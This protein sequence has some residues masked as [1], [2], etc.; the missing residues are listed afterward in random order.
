V[1]IVE[2]FISFIV[3]RFTSHHIFL[4]ASFAALFGFFYLKSIDLLYYSY[5]EKPGWNSK[6]FLSLFIIVLPITAINGF[7]MW[8]AAWIFFF[9]AYHVILYRD[10]RYLLI[11]LLACL[12]HWSFIL[13]N[14]VLLIYFFAGNRNLIY[15]PVAIASFFVPDSLI[16]V[17]NSIALKLGGAFQSRYTSYTNEEYSLQ[18]QEMWQKARWFLPLSKDLVFYFLLFAIIIICLFYSDRMKEKSEKNLFSFLLLFLSFVNFGKHIPNFEY[19]FQIIFILFATLYVLLFFLKL[20][21]NK[22][23]PLTIAGLFPI[24]LYTAVEFRIGSDFINLWIFSPGFG[25]P[26]FVKAIPLTQL[27]FPN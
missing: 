24:A 27:L 5:E 16:S 19:R 14:A 26:F 9:G 25:I 12:V 17:F 22:L 15:L 2:P 18:Y 6:I 10:A 7:R 4:F 3:S 8:T 13:T 20:P 23:H 11:T 21:G 1:D